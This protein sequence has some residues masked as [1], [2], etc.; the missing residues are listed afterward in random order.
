MRAER[1]QDFLEVLAAARMRDVDVDLLGRER[2]PECSARAIAERHRRER[3]AR[4]RPVDREQVALGGAVREYAV[5][6]QKHPREPAARA[7]LD[8]VQEL[9]R[10]ARYVIHDH[11]GHHVRL[12]RERGDVVPSA[13]ARV[14]ARVID[15]V[16]SG[17]G[18]V[19][20]L[21]ERQ[22][23]HAAEEPRE[24]PGEELAQ[25]RERAAEAVRVGDQLNA[26]LHFAGS[27]ADTGVARASAVLAGWAR[28]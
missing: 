9:R 5:E 3:Q 12:A 2:R 19:D 7:A 4:P 14:D 6:R 20:W 25:A 24:R 22:H 13:Q 1:A 21:E 18:A 17:I 26:V 28:A 23:V 11:V 8:E 10:A 15:R 27:A 16:E